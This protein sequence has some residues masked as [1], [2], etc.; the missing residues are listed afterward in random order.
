MAYEDNGNSNKATV[1]KLSAGTT[2]AVTS[3]LNPATAITQT[4]NKS[5][6]TITFTN[7]GARTFGTTPTLTATASSLLT[8]TF[9]SATS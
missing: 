4:V 7:P 5:S 2:T 3:N 8:P 6:Q 9:S 1:M